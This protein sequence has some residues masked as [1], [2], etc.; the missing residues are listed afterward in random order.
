MH[1]WNPQQ[2]PLE[3]VPESFDENAL[4]QWSAW[5]SFS[6]GPADLS[7]LLPPPPPPPAA[8]PLLPPLPH[9]LPIALPPPPPP[10]PSS[11]PDFFMQGYVPQTFGTSVACTFWASVLKVHVDPPLFSPSPCPH[12]ALPPSSVANNTL[13]PS[14]AVLDYVV[15]STRGPVVPQALWQPLYSRIR[16]LHVGQSPL[17]RPIFFVRQNGTAVGI[18]LTEA[19]GKRSHNLRDSYTPV[20]LGG[21]TTTQLRILWRGYPESRRQ[22]QIKD[23]TRNRNP[24]TLGK[25]A[26]HVGKSVQRFM[27]DPGAP[28]ADFDR[29]WMVGDGGVKPENV[30]LIG[31]VHTSAGTWQPILQ[32]AHP[33][34]AALHA[35]GSSS[36]ASSYM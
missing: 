28:E 8:L 25:L 2:P 20:D 12:W 31:V 26:T 9:P 6:S 32:L 24:I 22:L 11:Y 19:L 18:S 21:K 17:C 16:E 14:P 23:E 4:A 27:D 3:P 5:A 13:H 1:P 15:D 30:I 10:P 7:G 34:A 35:P 29:Q 33:Q 36:S